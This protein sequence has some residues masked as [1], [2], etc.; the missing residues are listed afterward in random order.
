MK[1]EYLLIHH[2]LLKKK[3]KDWNEQPANISRFNCL[4]WQTVID[5]FVDVIFRTINANKKPLKKSKVYLIL[6]SSS[7]VN[8]LI[9]EAG[10][11]DSR[12]PNWS[13]AKKF[14]TVAW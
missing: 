5:S 9:K 10:E 7:V 14:V 3:E 4:V 6:N 13:Q 12:L 8:D 11:R 1:Y 2:H